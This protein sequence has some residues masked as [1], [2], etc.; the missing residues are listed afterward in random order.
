MNKFLPIAIMFVLSGVVA[1]ANAGNP[2][3]FSG[4]RVQE[5]NRADGYTATMHN[6]FSFSARYEEGGIY[7]YSDGIDSF[8]NRDVLDS[9]TEVTFCRP[10]DRNFMSTVKNAAASTAASPYSNSKGVKDDSTTSSFSPI[11]M[12]TAI[13]STLVNNSNNQTKGRFCYDELDSSNTIDYRTPNAGAAV[14]C[15]PERFTAASFVDLVSGKTCSLK[16]DVP[17]KIGSRRIVRQLQ[18]ASRTT[19][20]EGYLGCYAN[21]ATGEP[22]LQL[23]ANTDNCSGGSGAECRLTCDWAEN[24]VCNPTELPSW[25][26]CKG[27]GSLVFKDDVINVLSNPGVSFDPSTGKRYKGSASFTCRATGSGTYWSLNSSNC[28]QM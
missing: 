2:Q 19:I 27:Q 4:S 7:Y 3:Y 22:T 28:T 5:V 15:S 13:S 16:L 24:L 20:G 1:N 21:P 25:G 23:H 9:S 12:E 17:I 8:G 11:Q 6:K 18:S 26:F 14:Y 10:G